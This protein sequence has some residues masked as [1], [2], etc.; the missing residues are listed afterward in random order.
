MT[1]REVAR[2][3]RVS[4]DRV[5]TWI[6]T[7]QLGAISTA[8]TRAGR[9]RYVVLPCHLAEWEQAQR[10]RPPPKPTPRRRPAGQVDYFPDL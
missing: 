6:R 7:G 3:L 2:Y 1:P 8:P 10:V 5:L 9:P 4:R